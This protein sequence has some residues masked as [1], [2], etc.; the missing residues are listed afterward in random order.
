MLDSTAAAHVATAVAAAA[1]AA[2]A[3]GHHVSLTSSVAAKD[4]HICRRDETWHVR[5]RRPETK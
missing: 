1:A 2:A 3:T 5:P 4:K